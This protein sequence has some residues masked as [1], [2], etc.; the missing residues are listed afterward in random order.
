MISCGRSRHAM[1]RSW[2]TSRCAAG[3]TRSPPPSTAGS[4]ADLRAGLVLEPERYVESAI[5]R[6]VRFV[7]GRNGHLDHLAEVATAATLRIADILGRGKV[8]GSV[9]VLSRDRE[10]ELEETL[11]VEGQR[12]LRKDQ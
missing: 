7:R 1:R 9:L 12:R 10:L 4:C 2:A 6:R 8:A 5:G 11:R 3:S